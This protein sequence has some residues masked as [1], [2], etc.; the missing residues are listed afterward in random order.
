[1]FQKDTLKLEFLG[2]GSS[3]KNEIV[4]GNYVS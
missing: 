1:M 3:L 4:P 2:L